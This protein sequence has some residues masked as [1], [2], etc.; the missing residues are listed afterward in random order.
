[1][2]DPYPIRPVGPDDF[3]ALYAVDQHAFH[4]RPLPERRR[5]E[6][7]RHF[8]FDRSLV[9]FD[10]DAPVGVAGAYSL[11]L[12]LPGAMAPAAGVTFIAVLPTYRRRG[13]LSSLIRRQFAEIRERGE[14]IAALWASESGIYGRYGYGPASWQASL[15][16]GRG[17]G[18]LGRPAPSAGPGLRLRLTEPESVRAELAK[19]Y[20]AMLPTRPGMFARDELWWNRVLATADDGLV[21]ADPL[22]CLLAE[23]GNGPRGYAIYS[24]TG[25]WDGPSFL[26]DSSLSIREMIATD[27]GATA[28]IWA[29]L[30]SR[31]LTTEFTA[32]L[33]PV[34]DPLLHLLADPRRARPRVADGL[35]VRLVDLPRALAQRR[36]A[37][38]ADVAIE[39]SDPLLAANRGTWRLRTE[40]AGP[41][42]A[43][44]PG[45]RL[46]VSPPPARPTWPSTSA[47]SAPPTWAAPGSARWRAP[48]WSPSVAGERWPRSLP[49]CPGIR[50][51]GARRSSELARRAAG[52]GRP[53][54]ARTAR[55]GPPGSGPRTRSARRSAHLAVTRSGCARGGT[56][57]AGSSGG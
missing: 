26:P 33:Q 53:R 24:G 18:Q 32:A 15:S 5:A 54:R 3:D 23:D 43:T 28:A 29:D 31:D 34:D 35:W 4:G 38:P 30:L 9:A 50:R 56:T 16:F 40:A 44:G 8:E 1:M 17:E 41:A 19:V 51:P 46:P 55:P 37:G 6:I 25:R 7:I 27:P 10:G 36:Y 13:I 47:R 49:P 20:E 14:A 45:W 22:R 21:D 2:A 57:G 11:R 39:V 52:L 42:R 48:G 12:C